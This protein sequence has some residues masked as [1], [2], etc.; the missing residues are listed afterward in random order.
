MGVL[1]LSASVAWPH[2]YAAVPYPHRP[3]VCIVRCIGG[4]ARWKHSAH[5]SPQN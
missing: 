4:G 1:T 5:S 2:V 3:C